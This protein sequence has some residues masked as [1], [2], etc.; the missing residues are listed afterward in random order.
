MNETVGTNLDRAQRLALFA[1]VG[2]SLLLAL[3]AFFSLPQFFQSYLTAFLFWMQFSLGCLGLMML[4]HLS[5][6]RWGFGIRRLLEAG[7]M[8]LPLMLALWLPVFLGARYL[9][10]WARPAE[11]A[12]NALLQHKQPYLNVPFFG[13]RAL[14]YFAIWTLLAFFLRRWSLRQDQ[15]GDPL[16]TRRMRLISRAGA[17]LFVLTVTFATLDWGM[18]LEPDWTSTIYG[19]IFMTGQGL[20]ALTFSIIVLSVLVDRTVLRQVVTLERFGDLGNLTMAFVILWTYMNLSQFLIIWSGNLP[21][22]VTWYLHRTAGGWSYVAIFLAIF[23]FVVPL[24]L[25]FSHDLKRKPARLARLAGALLLVHFIF[26]FWMVQPSF[27]RSG[28]HIN[29]LDIVA[30][31]AIGG[32]WVAC[33]VWQLKGKPLLPRNDPR[34]Q[35]AFAHEH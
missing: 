27:F 8:T 17:V 28:L 19:A 3:G 32:L 23:H 6:G 30:P 26:L 29:W 22:E 16:L 13:V 33:F 12:Q 1:A 7:A 24:L 2:G 9:Y 20:T 10:L 21:E 35:E 15:T 34:F 5:G 4:H 11:V 14:I 18:S 25:L 31:I